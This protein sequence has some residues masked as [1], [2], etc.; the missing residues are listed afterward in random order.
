[1]D[2]TRRLHKDDP[3]VVL[4]KSMLKMREQKKPQVREKPK[5]NTTKGV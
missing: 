4:A 3:L 1:M 2:K 5:T